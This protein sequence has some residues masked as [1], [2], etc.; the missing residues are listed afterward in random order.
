MVRM[1]QINY[2]GHRTFSKDIK[3]GRNGI[4]GE[5]YWNEERFIKFSEIFKEEKESTFTVIKRLNFGVP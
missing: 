4:N 5:I 3:K 1:I 2:F